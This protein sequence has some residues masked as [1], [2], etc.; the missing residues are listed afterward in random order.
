MDNLK[1]VPIAPGHAQA[2]LDILKRTTD[3]ERYLRFFFT[4]NYFTLASTVQYVTPG[5][6]MMGFIA[7]D[8]DERPLGVAHVFIDEDNLAEISILVAHDS[9]RQGV[10]RALMER[11]LD[12]CGSQ[13]VVVNL[14][15][16]NGPMHKLALTL[17]FHSL[18]PPARILTMVRGERCA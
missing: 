17:G 3:E 9:R 14:L 13:Q 12:A 5:D 11:L 8:G 4:A 1:I 7:F 15:M 10:G 6:G 16:E 2:Y 18:G